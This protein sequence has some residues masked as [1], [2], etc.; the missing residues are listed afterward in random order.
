MV[1]KTAIKHSRKRIH[2]STEA[3]K[4]FGVIRPTVIRWVKAGC[5]ATIRRTKRDRYR[6]NINEVTKWLKQT[7]RTTLPGKP[8]EA[9]AGTQFKEAQTELATEKARIAKMK[10]E[11]MEN[12]LHDVAQC[13]E[14]RLRQIHEVKQA[15][16]GM[17]RSLPEE[18]VGR[19]PTA[20]GTILRDRIDRILTRFS[21]NGTGK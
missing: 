6:L 2:N 15:L 9:Q 4:H 10:R 7:G 16:Y 20:I 19:K 11:G 1:M 21:S 5:P 3:A 8:A 14:R 18:L 17:A 13:K 12:R